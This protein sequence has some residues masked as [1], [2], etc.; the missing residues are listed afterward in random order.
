MFVKSLPLAVKSD[1]TKVPYEVGFGYN[2]G[3]GTWYIDAS[4]PDPG[5]V[6]IHCAWDANLVATS[7]NYESSNMP[8]YKSASAPYTDSSGAADVAINTADTTG[9]WI[10]ENPS[11]AYVPIVG[12]GATVTNMTIA[13]AGGAAGGAMFNISNVNHRRGRTKLV[14]TTAGYYRQHTHGKQA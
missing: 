9:L 5:A 12:A 11:T 6:S 3:V 4:M 10:T 14:V 13:V 1:G 8:A 7:I 2:L